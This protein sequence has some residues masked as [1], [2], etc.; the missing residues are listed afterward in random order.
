MPNTTPLI[1]KQ[2]NV[3]EIASNTFP[4]LNFE[5]FWNAEGELEY[6]VNQKPNQKLK[7]LN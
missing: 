2:D 4:Y 6:Q 5:F 3:L 1:Y 7:Y